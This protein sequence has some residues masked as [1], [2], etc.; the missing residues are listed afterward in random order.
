METSI[1]T[2]VY[3][4]EK[5]LE[6]TLDSI[7]NQTYQDWESILINDNSSDSSLEIA[8]K[9][10]S[11]DSR[12]KIISNDSSVGPA[13]ARNI[14]IEFSSGRYIAF[15]DSDDVWMGEKLFK[16]INF[17]KNN[18]INFCFSGY[19]LMSEDGAFLGSVDV[20]STITY[21]TLLKHNVVGCL[22]AV[23]DTKVLG[24][25]YMPLILKR[26]DFGLWLSIL[27]KG[28]VG[29]SIQLPLAKYRLRSGSVSHAKLNTMMYTWRLYRDIEKLSFFSTFYNISTH[30]FSAVIKRYKHKF[31][32]PGS[33]KEK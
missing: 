24:K 11:K 29:Y 27:K 12:F 16:Q 21:K 13:K 25:M 10:A 14:G 17:M 18:D 8:K 3:N 20:P 22:T 31:F 23:Y 32:I 26:H 7:L 30:L 1:I 6:E 19:E 5:Y 33:S 2:P 28:V 15:L 9:Y 4:C